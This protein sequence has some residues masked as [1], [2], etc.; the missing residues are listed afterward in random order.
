MCVVEPDVVLNFF[1]NLGPL[2]GQGSRIHFFACEHPDTSVNSSCF[3]GLQTI[4]CVHGLLNLDRILN[5]AKPIHFGCV[6][7][8]RIVKTNSRRTNQSINYE[9][10]T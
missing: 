2:V 5:Q 3:R 8:S 9:G 10:K 4:A 6:R 1:L 7:T